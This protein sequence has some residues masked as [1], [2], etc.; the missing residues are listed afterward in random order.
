M[1]AQIPDRRRTGRIRD[2]F[3]SV[4]FCFTLMLYLYMSSEIHVV[5]A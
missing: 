3:L 2:T 5:V 4:M 1:Q